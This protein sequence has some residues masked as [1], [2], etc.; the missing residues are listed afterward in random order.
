MLCWSLSVGPEEGCS[1][2]DSA[3]R[4]RRLCAVGDKELCLHLCRITPPSRHTHPSSLIPRVRTRCTQTTQAI[5]FPPV[6]AILFAAKSPA[7]DSRQVLIPRL[8]TGAQR[9]VG[10]LW[11]AGPSL[12]LLHSD[13]GGRDDD[14]YDDGGDDDES[15]RRRQNPFFQ[16][17]TAVYT[18]IY[19]PYFLPFVRAISHLRAA[20]LF[21]IIAMRVH[22][23]TLGGGLNDIIRHRHHHHHHHRH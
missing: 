17:F 4:S 3:L 23:H 9:T 22:T 21:I 20:L 6:W 16:P 12:V 7:I 8:Q 13:R 14:D 19:V 18:Y 11:R 15:N 1:D 5:R 2:D 10:G